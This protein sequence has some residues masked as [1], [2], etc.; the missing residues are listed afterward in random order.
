MT[1]TK[2]LE[3]AFQELK[4]FHDGHD[5]LGAFAAFPDDVVAQDL[6]PLHVPAAELFE[7]E[8]GFDTTAYP[9]LLAALLD[10]SPTMQWRE[11]Y[12]DTDIGA[13]FMDRFGCYEIIGRDAPFASA[14]IR[15]FLVYQ[16]PHLHYPWHHHPAEELYVVVAGEAEFHIEGQGAKILRSGE[17]SFHPSGVPHALTSHDHPVLA[18]VIWRDDFDVAPVWS[19]EGLQKSA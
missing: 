10:L 1:D 11:T 14:K 7:A 3:A 6:A 19:D 13:D 5:A 15:S 18:Y 9:R 16:P 8:Q 12:K 17:S 2:V 4:A